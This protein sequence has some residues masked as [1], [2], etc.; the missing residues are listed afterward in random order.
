MF[1]TVFTLF[2]FSG[3]SGTTLAGVELGPLDATPEEG[4]ETLEQALGVVLCVLIFLGLLS[5]LLCCLSGKGKAKNLFSVVHLLFCSEKRV[6]NDFLFVC[7]FVFV[8][9]F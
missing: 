4:D 6:K 5:I 7:L 2:A 1:V 8:R 3:G 9:K